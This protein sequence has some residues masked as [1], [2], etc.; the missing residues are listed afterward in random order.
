MKGFMLLSSL[1]YYP[2]V[3]CLKA[4]ITSS[5]ASY[6]YRVVALKAYLLMCEVS[7]RQQKTLSEVHFT[8]LYF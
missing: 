4:T 6:Y 3:N 8:E 7:K 1:T 5:A 2:P